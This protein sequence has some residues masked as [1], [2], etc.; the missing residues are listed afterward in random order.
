MKYY[1]SAITGFT[2]WGTFALVLK[3]LSAF[4]SIEILI[5]RVIYATVAII[6]AGILFRRKQTKQSIKTLQQMP[7]TALRK[8]ILNLLMSA[9]ALSL[10]WFLFI[11]V[12]NAISVN[13]TSLAYLICPILTTFLAAV[14]LKEKL[15]KGQWLAVCLSLL[16]CLILA[17]GHFIDLFYSIIIALSYAIYLV[18]QKNKFDVDRFFTLTIHITAGAI[19][20][21]P[22]FLLMEQ[23]TEKTPV[24]HVLILVIA[25]FYTIIP[26]FLNIYALKKLSSSVVGTL[27]YLNPVISFLLAVLYYNEAINTAQIIGFSLIVI[28]VFIFNFAY[29]KAQKGYVE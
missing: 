15:N 27:L 13:A 19:F 1:L 28:A 2:I 26:L 23:P 9:L 8:W 17:Y 11:Y 18:L 25:V 24:F 12:M 16:S 7:T 3:P 10:N 20:L 5:Y 22:A 6:L 29:F 14:F 21:I 4:P